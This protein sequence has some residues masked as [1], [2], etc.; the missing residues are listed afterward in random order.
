MRYVISRQMW[1]QIQVIA[2]FRSEKIGAKERWHIDRDNDRSTLLVYSVIEAKASF[3]PHRR[4]WLLIRSTH[5]VQRLF[6]TCKH[7][8]ILIR[9]NTLVNKNG[10]VSTNHRYFSHLQVIECPNNRRFFGIVKRWVYDFRFLQPL[11][12]WVLLNQLFLF[13]AYFSWKRCI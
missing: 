1:P 4:L 2:I 3:A 8:I 11:E 9:R 6:W 5:E 10:C 7:M 13:G 12:N